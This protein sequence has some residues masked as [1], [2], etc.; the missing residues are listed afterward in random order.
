MT[1]VFLVTLFSRRGNKLNRR[2]P[3]LADA[4]DFLPDQ[5]TIDGEIVALDS[6]GKPSFSA[7]QNSLFRPTSLYFYAFDLFAYRGKDFRILIG[8]LL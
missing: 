8:W 6:K 7:L 5:T 4:F 1:R 3:P 2:F